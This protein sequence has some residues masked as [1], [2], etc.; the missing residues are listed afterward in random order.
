MR[1]VLLNSG[2]VVIL[3]LSLVILTGIL[4][5]PGVAGNGSD[6]RKLMPPHSSA[7]GATAGEWSVRW[8][9]WADSLPVDHHPLFDTADCSA[10]QSGD[11][12]F[13][14]GTFTTITGEDGVVR[15]VANR[16]CT[17]PPGKALFFPI[18]AA[19]TSTLEGNGET[20]EEL[21]ELV[22]Y[23]ADHIDPDAL[24]CI[25]D[26]VAANDL[27]EFRTESRLFE[28]GPLPENNL[29][30]FFGFDAPAGS[31]SPA[32][33]DGVFVMVKPLSAGKHTIHFGGTLVF[34]LADDGFDFIFDLDITYN[35]TVK[36]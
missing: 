3:G 16:D 11:V 35:I 34:T 9:L 10:G 22:V 13:L 20:E 18:V 8:N 17:I 29:L 21:R 2:T 32:V 27:I 5:M 4:I 25:V 15:G 23:F 26:G 31:T 30:Q 36:K 24:F 19:E 33:S 12:W 6:N 7:H 14:G 1:K 28:Y